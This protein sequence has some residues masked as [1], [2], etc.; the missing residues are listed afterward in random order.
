[1]KKLLPI[2][3][4]ALCTQVSNVVASEA[5]PTTDV[6]KFSTVVEHIRNHYVN[7]VEDHALF[8]NAIRGMISS[9]DPHS[10]YLDEMEFDDLRASTSG[11]FGGLG[12]EVTMEEGF[13]KIISP[14]DDSPATKADLRSGD[15]II[16]IDD[17]P[18]RDLGLKDAVDK[19]KGKPGSTIQLTILRKGA[20]KPLVKTVTREVIV[21]RSVKSRMLDDNYAYIRVAQSDSGS[22]FRKAVKQL[23]SEH[24]DK[25]KGIV[26]DLRNN[27]G[28]IL[29]SAV[30][31]SDTFL[32]KAN[33][34]YDG[35]IVYTKGKMANSEMREKASNKDLTNNLPLVV[36]VNGGSASASEIVAGA[37]QDHKRA[38]I[39]GTTTF[40]KGSVQTII[41]FRDNKSGLKLTTALYYTPSGRSIQATGIKPDIEVDSLEMPEPSSKKTTA[42]QLMIKE[43]DLQGHLVS[44]KA[45]IQDNNKLVKDNILYSDYQLQQALNLLKGIRA[46]R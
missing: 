40:G 5:L 37:L 46:Y 41:P 13:V 29:N 38:I 43:A 8:E 19:M 3:S 7:P 11:K 27:P 18:V 10:T 4:I 36:L 9:L 2:L 39:M 33:I 34:G 21:V 42:D 26:L 1:M 20:E 22:E 45:Q 6:R 15:L 35:L 24:K 25:I 44:N 23:M 14:V 31:I 17:T 16:K 28:G 30:E 32:D 12:I